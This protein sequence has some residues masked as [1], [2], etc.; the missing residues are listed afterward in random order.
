[1]IRSPSS[2]LINYETQNDRKYLP[3][4]NKVNMQPTYLKDVIYPLETTEVNRNN[5]S[6]GV[7]FSVDQST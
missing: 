5:K 7:A 3:E 6:S 4:I 2:D 1:L